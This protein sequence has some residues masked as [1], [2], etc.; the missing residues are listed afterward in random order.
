MGELF[1]KMKSMITSFNMHKQFHF[2]DFKKR[3]FV[4][5][6]IIA[7]QAGIQEFR[8]ELFSI[9]KSYLVL[10]SESLTLNALPMNDN[11]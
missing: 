10:H 2:S 9:K 3:Q 5:I 7:T 6:N 1:F 11:P 4:H 8:V